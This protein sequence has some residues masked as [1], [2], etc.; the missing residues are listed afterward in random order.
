[1]LAI[2]N[3]RGDTMH[4]RIGLVVAAIALSASVALAQTAGKPKGILIE[5]EDFKGLEQF[6]MWQTH[7]GRWYA[8]EHLS[9]I[10]SR[11]AYAVANEYSIG[12][13]MART[14]D[15]EL[16]AGPY[17]VWIKVVLWGD[18]DDSLEI[19]LNGSKRTYAWG[20]AELRKYGRAYRWLP[21]TIT[22]AK[23]GNTIRVK[24]LKASMQDFGESPRPPCKF[25]VLDSIYVG[26]AD[27]PLSVFKGRNHSTLIFGNSEGILPKVETEPGEPA[28]EPPPQKVGN[29][30]E[31]GSF[32][33]GV[34]H[35]WCAKWQGSSVPNL[36]LD[37]SQ[38]ERG[39]SPDGQYC[40]RNWQIPSPSIGVA[41]VPLITKT[42]R[43][44]DPGAYT[45][46]AWAR[47]R[48]E[49][50]SRKP[51]SVGVVIMAPYGNLDKKVFS[52]Q[53]T[54]TPS[55]QRIEFTEQLK[56]G[57][58]YL[59]L[60]GRP[61]WIDGVQLERGE[62]ATPYT[63][64][65]EAEVGI[66]TD[67]PGKVF[68]ADRPVTV[69]LRAA[70]AK[71]YKQ[72]ALEVSCK[73]YDVWDRL[74]FTKKF[75]VAVSPGT[76]KD[77]EIDLTP[78]SMG[79]FRA[80]LEVDGVDG[81]QDQM[82]FSV[83]PAPRTAGIDRDSWLGVMPE[84]RR[85][86]LA[87]LQ[88]AGY[89]WSQ[90]I[91]FQ[92]SGF[93]AYAER[94]PGEI[95][96]RDEDVALPRRYGMEPVML[97]HVAVRRLPSWVEPTATNKCMPKDLELWKRFVHRTVSHYK[98]LVKYWQFS[99]DIHHFMNAE[100]HATLLKATYETCKRA[101]PDCTV[102]GWRFFRR[103]VP[104][105]AENMK[106]TE[107]YSDILYGGTRED[108]KEFGKP[109]HSYRFFG[110]ASMFSFQAAG[111]P[112]KL[113]A[114]RRARQDT[115]TG[116]FGNFGNH[117]SSVGRVDVLYFYM[118]YL[119]SKPQ[120]TYI[121]KNAFEHDATLTLG[122]ITYRILE[123]FLRKPE[124]VGKLRATR[125]IQAYLFETAKSPVAILWATGG[126]RAT[127]SFGAGAAEAE[128]FDGLGNPFQPERTGTVTRLALNRTPFILVSKGL[129]AE[130]LGKLVTG[131]KIDVRVPIHRSIAVRDNR[132]LLDV[133]V[134]NNSDGPLPAS[135]RISKPSLFPLATGAPEQAELGT[136]PAGGDR[137]GSFPL[138]F[139]M[140][141]SAEYKSLGVGVKVGDDAF[142][143]RWILWFC[144][145]K[146]T[147]DP[148]RV[149]GDLAEW[150]NLKPSKITTTNVSHA[151]R[152]MRQVRSGAITGAEELTQ[153]MAPIIRG[154]DD[155]SGKFYT[156]WDAGNLYVA[157]EVRDD[158][159]E[160][161][162]RV[163]IFLDTDLKGDLGAD[164]P[165]EDDV[166]IL[167][168]IGPASKEATVTF[169]KQVASIPAASQRIPSGSRIEIAVPWS[170]IKVSPRAATVLGLDVAL[171]DVDNNT[172][173]AQLVW[174]GAAHEW[175]DPT[176]FGAL[177]LSE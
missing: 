72:K 58:Y 27:E 67:V 126:E 34:G 169:G 130:Q 69:K 160:K 172:P 64:Y 44:E 18:A 33:V 111:D 80:E 29:L 24:A 40:L 86:I 176:G 100:E 51:P 142:R 61:F 162:D 171:I 21:G 96:W 43:I 135:V 2:Q 98:H 81:S 28:F 105:A 41:V 84:H 133:T 53:L 82:V 36:N 47:A 26:P 104:G 102:L 113:G 108:A 85:Y 91:R 92:K 83:V 125:A 8:K 170:Q 177:V 12:A 174:S 25:F 106:L 137:V 146:R 120:T 90:D 153:K 166:T 7:K 74:V 57:E 118:A 114:M 32:E 19:D 88:R 107:P 99:D 147:A 56:K 95:G 87:S 97:L 73:L 136:V 112:E 101:D 31:N 116:C 140:T 173:H 78:G 60:S 39:K 38:L 79:M 165:S 124:C 175:A 167:Y 93:W 37:P 117:A 161:G 59:H 131:A 71:S 42:F 127:V 65:S 66:V 143:K 164:Q 159:V 139:D 9:S 122:T 49:S 15:R 110:S 13:V 141:Q 123:H 148:I 50:T 129:S 132:V 77:T 157:I 144:S 134:R 52:K 121:S 14:L 6:G 163:A 103:D 45:F 35:G 4:Q 55:W 89:K 154:N 149:D 119:Y 156:R 3:E 68:F 158:L 109:I 23:A 30:I 5:G 94:K 76:S 48:A 17:N 75:P 16:P 10:V 145:A 128:F 1:M 62:K 168:D 151:T 20:T 11:G 63:R 22:T 54:I 115:V 70:S 152:R 155:I 46:S 150:T 138:N